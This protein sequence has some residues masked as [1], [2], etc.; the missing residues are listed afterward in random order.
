MIG[1]IMLGILSS[2]LINPNGADGL[3]YG[4]YSFFFKQVVTVVVSSIYAFGITYFMLVVINK[5][6]PVK[7]E[8]VE[9]ESG[10][11]EALHGEQ[12][13]L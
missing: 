10:L 4:N 1:I 8:Q 6:T 5:I 7:V 11:D 13:Y 2:K 9:E 3:I 12:A